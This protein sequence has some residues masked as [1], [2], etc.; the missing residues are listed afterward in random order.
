[1]SFLRGMAQ[2]TVVHSYIGV[3]NCSEQAG[4]RAKWIHMGVSRKQ[5]SSAKA[6]LQKDKTIFVNF[7]KTKK[8]YV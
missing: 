4:T 7:K 2:E 5:W 3:L 8:D 6:K 1:M